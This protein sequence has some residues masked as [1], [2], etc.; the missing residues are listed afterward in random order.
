M[1][2]NVSKLLPLG[3]KTEQVIEWEVKIVKEIKI[4][5]TQ[6]QGGENCGHFVVVKVL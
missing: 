1:M 2:S 5:V 6:T 3:Y 4:E